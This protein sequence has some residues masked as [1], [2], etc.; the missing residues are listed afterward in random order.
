MT[1]STPARRTLAALIEDALIATA[2]RI[3]TRAP[4]YQRPR[5]RTQLAAWVHETCIRPGRILVIPQIDAPR[6]GR[7]DTRSGELVVMVRRP[8]GT[9]HVELTRVRLRELELPS[10]VN[11]QAEVRLWLYQQGFH[12]PDDVSALTEEV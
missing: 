1:T 8:N 7:L 5:L 3:V 10:G 11:A 4:D 12:I 9:E 2:T 6:R